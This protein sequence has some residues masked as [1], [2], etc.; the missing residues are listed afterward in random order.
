MAILTWDETGQHWG[1]TGVSNGVIYTR[2]GP[3]TGYDKA[4]AWNGLT[5]VNQEPEGAEPQ[6]FYADNILYLSLLSAEKWKATIEAFTY[7]DMFAQCDGTAQVQTGPMFVGQQDRVPFGFSWQTKIVNDTQATAAGTMIHVAY[8][9]LASPSSKNA[10]TINDSP[11]ITNFSWSITGTPV[12]VPNMKPSAYL[13]FD[14]RKATTE[15]WK[16][17]TYVL[18]GTSGTEAMLPTPAELVTLL[19]P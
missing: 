11:E 12:N 6:D 3:S 7:P 16:A 13:K 17:L 18:Y 9:C 5:A 19:H 14:S 4:A 2:S 1:E 15:Q 10:Q 8:G